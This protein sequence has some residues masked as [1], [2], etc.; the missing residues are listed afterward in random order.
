MTKESFHKRKQELLSGLKKLREFSNADPERQRFMDDLVQ[1]HFATIFHD[2]LEDLPEGIEFERA[3]NEL[4][5]K[6]GLAHRRTLD[7]IR[8]SAH[9][10]TDGAFGDSLW[11]S[12]DLEL[13]S[14]TFRVWLET[15]DELGNSLA[16]GQQESVRQALTS[17]A[18][19]IAGAKADVTFHSRQTVKE[20]FD[21]DV[22][23]Y[24]R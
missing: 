24:L 23:R 21:G 1:R 19:D 5:K 4:W 12:A 20:R 8:E 22:W 2:D 17:V 9:E 11:V 3:R 16:N 13:T 14:V 6:L 10:V 15:D 7:R 18:S